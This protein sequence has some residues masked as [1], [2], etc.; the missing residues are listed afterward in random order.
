M[1]QPTVFLCDDEQDARD[2]LAF[3]LRQAGHDVQAFSGGHAL[4][5]AITQLPRPL[6]AVF[7]LDLD[8][9]P[10]DGDVLHERLIAQGIGRRSPVIFLSGKGTLARAVAAM[11]RGALDYVEKP[12][13]NGKLLP[14]LD[15]ACALE[16]RLNKEANRFDFLASMWAELTPQQRRASML[17]RQGLANKAI[18]AELDISDRMVEVH[19]ARACEKLGVDNAKGLAA[20]VAEVETLGINV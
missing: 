16:A 6:R 11:S 4:L 2:G 20:T 3:L 17:V 9:P 8:M 1:S 14:L 13:T 5:E 7:V 15:K 10:M 19:V 12:Y 18:A